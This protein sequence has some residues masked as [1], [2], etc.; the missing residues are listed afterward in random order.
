M[1][2]E[3]KKLNLKIDI[4]GLELGEEEKKLTPIG[5]STRVMSNVMFGY[6]TQVRGL[7]KPER[8]QFWRIGKQFDKA[9]KEG[10]ETIELDSTDAGFI[11]KCF[12]E[13]KLNPSELL[14]RVE[15]L[16]DSMEGYR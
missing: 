12:R 4:T 10:I 1:S 9:V 8:T 6:S 14:E 2:T 15:S 3:I 5:L 16:V 7:S 13:S 11:R